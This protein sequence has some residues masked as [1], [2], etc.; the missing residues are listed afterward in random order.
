MTLRSPRCWRGDNRIKGIT[1]QAFAASLAAIAIHSGE[2][3][4]SS[5]VGLPLASLGALIPD[6]DHP[7]SKLGRRIYPLSCIFYQFAGHRGFFHSLAFWVLLSV[8]FYLINQRWIPASPEA[9]ILLSVGHLSHLVGDMFFGRHGVQLLWPIKRR[10]RI[11]PGTWAVGGLYEFIFLV[12][13][14]FIASVF[15]GMAMPAWL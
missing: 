1:H 3:S 6:C 13:F 8:G 9:W 7:E 15:S 11:M 12:I 2:L 5:W 10:I 14:M 4:I